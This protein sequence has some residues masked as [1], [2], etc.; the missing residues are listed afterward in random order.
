[1]LFSS[2]QTL[3]RSAVVLLLSIGLGATAALPG[4][5][6]SNTDTLIVAV[7]R[8]ITNLDP[9][10]NSGDNAT[11]EMLT[12]VYEPLINIAVTDNP[13]GTRTASATD[14]A[15]ALAE[16]FDWSPDGKRVTF[17]LRE[18]LKFS[19]GDPIDAAAVK[20]TY[21]RIFDQKGVSALLIGMAG[22]TNKDYIRVIDPRTIEMDVDKANPILFANLWQF[23]NSTLNSNVVR[24]HMTAADPFAHEWL[25]ISTKGTESGPFRLA[26]WEP[27][28]QWVLERNENYW[29]TPAKLSRVVFKIIPDPS[30]RLAQLASGAVDVAYD[31]PLRDIKM[32][33]GNPDVTVH[34]NVSREVVYLGMNNNT[35]PFDNKLVRQAISYALP[36]DV[37][38][39]QV[40]NGYAIQL[41]S[42]IPE[43]TPTHTGE[44]FV[45]K[46]DPEKA[47]ELL[48]KAGFPEGLSTTLQIP[49]GTQ[50][51][52]EIAVYVQQSLRAAGIQIT[53][54]EMP[55]AAHME[56]LQKRTL[57]FFIG[58]WISFNN[59]PFYHLFF[60]LHSSCC[61]Y[62]NYKNAE[63]DQMIDTYMLSTDADARN[64]ALVT[65]QKQIADDAPWAFLYQ[66]DHIFA[67]RSNVKGY[68]YYSVD[69]FTRYKYLYKE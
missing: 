69:T 17:K 13:D 53:I 67:T 38:I 16:K 5:A 34:R 64:A 58:Q 50:Q 27:G 66:P 3:L 44:F 22:V 12:N 23:G 51:A 20:F 45:Y 1:M 4:L 57:G 30:S 59:D 54:Q 10:L 65:A 49:A 37:V 43:G 39:N 11:Q 52:K 28:I 24:P 29:G 42:P 25:K 63:L 61:N 21:D 9:T 47:K 60:N 6:Q 15:G 46:N 2:I 7:P 14:F 35:P 56:Q 40:M 36:Y 18:G 55:G 19:N 32:L 31:L 68:V 48:A 41:T 33:E 62:T 26:S 8:D